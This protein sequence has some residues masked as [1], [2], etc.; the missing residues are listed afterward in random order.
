MRLLGAEVVPV[1][2]GSQTLKDAVNEALRDWVASVDET[3][4]VLGT[5][6][7]P[8]PFPEMVRDFH[9]VIGIEAR[10]QVL[11]LVGRLPDVVLA[12]VGGGSSAMRSSPVPRRHRRAPVGLEAGRG[13]GV[14]AARVPVRLRHPR[15]PPR[16]VHAPRHAGR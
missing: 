15:R 10:A 1:T 3:H 5:V 9:R 12:C 11:D 4:Y 7:G 6:T 2:T 8:R 13:P 14:R 16:R